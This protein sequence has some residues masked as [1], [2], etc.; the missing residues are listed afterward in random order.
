MVR[1]NL[2][3]LHGIKAIKF[4]MNTR[5]SRAIYCIVV[6][7]SV[8]KINAFNLMSSAFLF[9]KECSISLSV[10]L[11]PGCCWKTKNKNKKQFKHVSI[12]LLSLS[13]F[14]SIASTC[15]IFVDPPLAL[16]QGFY[17]FQLYVTSQIS[18]LW[19]GISHEISHFQKPDF[20]FNVSYIFAMNNK[21]IE[22]LIETSSF[23]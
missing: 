15:F 23:N 5:R 9:P 17:Y 3:P 20:F 4:Q 11:I 1:A 16:F 14:I 6:W 7:N 8:L 10:L 2:S 18:A 19:R 21:V 12:T 13:Y 22:S